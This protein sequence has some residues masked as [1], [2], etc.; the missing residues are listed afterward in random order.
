MPKPEL[1]AA[2]E[3]PAPS[4][5]KPGWTERAERTKI[6]TK[7]EPIKPVVEPPE[8]RPVEMTLEEQDVFALMGVSPLVKL[9][10]EVKNP[11]SVIINIIQPGQ[12]QLHQLN[13]PQNQLFLKEQ[14]LK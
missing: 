2:S 6:T 13:Q 4:L 10:P 1:G 14:A 3:I 11:K 9:E 8:I 5:G 12:L 7:A